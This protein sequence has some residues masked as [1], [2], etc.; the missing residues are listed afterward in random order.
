[1][2]PDTLNLR[3]NFGSDIIS[4][5]GYGSKEGNNIDNFAI[6]WNID[7]IFGMLEDLSATNK[8]TRHFLIDV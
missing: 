6:P 5:T 8:A 1:M 3:L 4:C 7:N 2:I